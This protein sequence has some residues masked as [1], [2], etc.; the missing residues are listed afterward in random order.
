MARKGR[1]ET[2]TTIFANRS[3]RN[4]GYGVLTVLILFIVGIIGL[5]LFQRTGTIG[6][7]GIDTERVSGKSYIVKEGDTLWSIAE[8]LYGDPYQWTKL[9]ESNKIQDPDKIEKGTSLIIPELLEERIA[10]AT[11][12][13]P[14]KLPTATPLPTRK[15]TEVATKPRS[16]APAGSKGST[17]A[18][19]PAAGSTVPPMEKITGNTYT[20]VRGD[21][22]WNIAVRAYGDGFRW[23]EIARSN[24]L[25]NPHL[26]H[27]G[28]KFILPR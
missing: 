17:A 5:N 15:P 6:E 10:Q 14:T 7:P 22:L 9:A 1:V 2:S 16:D 23:V 20:V 4:I 21:N 27:A 13:N 11:T 18:Q 8:K 19:L 26:I 28:N 3:Y 24:K 12:P 25:V